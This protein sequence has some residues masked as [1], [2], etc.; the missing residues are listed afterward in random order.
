MFNGMFI[1]KKKQAENSVLKKATWNFGYITGTVKEIGSI[2]DE[3]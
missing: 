3:R 2:S 1:S